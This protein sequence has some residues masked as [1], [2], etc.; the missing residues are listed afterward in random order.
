MSILSLQAEGISPGS[1]LR[2]PTA[3]NKLTLDP[4]PSPLPNISVFPTSTKLAQV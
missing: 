3:G 2:P 4:M 1:I